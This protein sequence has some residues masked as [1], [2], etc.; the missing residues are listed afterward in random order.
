MHAAQQ[1][2]CAPTDTPTCPGL[3]SCPATP[4]HLLNP[5]VQLGGRHTLVPAPVHGQRSRQQLVGALAS[6]CRHAQYW[7]TAVHTR[8]GGSR[9]SSGQEEGG[10][11]SA[12]VLACGD[13]PR[14]GTLLCA[15]GDVRTQRESR[16][17]SGGR[18]ERRAAHTPC[19]SQRHSTLCFS[20]PPAC[21]RAPAVRPGCAC[22]D[23]PAAGQCPTNT[24]CLLSRVVSHLTSGRLSSTVCRMSASACC[25]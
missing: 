5:A 17:I 9:C 16:L 24:F 1:Q 3:L 18:C 25:R 11:L 2:A 21:M 20:R 7:H 6:Q 8:R 4:A 10:S 14:M 12:P 13:L 19:S 22:Q 23:K 15:R